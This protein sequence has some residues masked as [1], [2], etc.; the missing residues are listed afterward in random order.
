M[1]L[2]EQ[3]AQRLEQLR[4]AGVDIP[5]A[6]QQEK[7]QE[8]AVQA[9]S[10]DRG[11]HSE[12]DSGGQTDDTGSLHSPEMAMSRRVDIDLDILKTSGFIRPD[13]SRS[14]LS[15]EFR[16]IKRPLIDNAMEKA[17]RRS[18]MAT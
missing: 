16:V 4:K 11:A 13:A 7:T 6:K 12:S 3:A 10:P 1:S 9:A 17:L 5:D 8:P 15:D 2:I 18:R 14:R